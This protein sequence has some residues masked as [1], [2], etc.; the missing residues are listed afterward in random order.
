MAWTG[1]SRIGWG[2]DAPAAGGRKEEVDGGVREWVDQK[3]PPAEAIPAAAEAEAFVGVCGEGE[4]IN[5]QR[6][7]D[8]R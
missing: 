6:G 3:P 8:D 1:P 4:G 7:T 5:N 2:G